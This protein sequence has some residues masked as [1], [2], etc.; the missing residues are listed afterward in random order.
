MENTEQ[1]IKKWQS[2]LHDMTLRMIHSH[3]TRQRKHTI[4]EPNMPL[5]MRSKQMGL[6]RKNTIDNARPLWALS[7]VI[8]SFTL[9]SVSAPRL[10]FTHSLLWT[11]LR[12]ICT[13]I[14]LSEHRQR[15]RETSMKE[16]LKE[17]NKRESK[18]IL[19]ALKST[20]HA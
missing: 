16:R 3:R 12:I 6:E 9:L 7:L 19:T 10:A 14:N 13:I 20:I 11:Y 2:N 4:G 1:I 15:K 8:L 17:W 18:I 5:E